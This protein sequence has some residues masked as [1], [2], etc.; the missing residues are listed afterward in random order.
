MS[1]R[2]PVSGERIFFQGATAR[3]RGL[4]AAFE[5]ITGKQIVVSPYCHVMGAYGAALQAMQ[6]AGEGASG[7]RGL[8]VLEQTVQLGYE[9]CRQCAN[10]CTITRETW[11]WRYVSWVL[12]AAAKFLYSPRHGRWGLVRVRCLL[13]G[14]GPVLH[15]KK[16]G[17]G[18]IGIPAAYLSMLIISALWTVFC[19][20]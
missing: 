10:V 19:A 9:T 2:G 18:V 13:V 6:Q 11:Q 17:R 1:A 5:S 3:N 20:R 4:V 15:D 16:T 8:D 7:F 12:C 14:P